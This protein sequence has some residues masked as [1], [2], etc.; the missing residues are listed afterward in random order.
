MEFWEQMLEEYVLHPEPM[1]WYELP[2]TKL[3]MLIHE[4]FD[5]VQTL[6]DKGYVEWAGVV[7]KQWKDTL[8]RITPEGRSYW[9]ANVKGR[10]HRPSSAGPVPRWTSAQ[11]AVAQ[12]PV[13]V[14]DLARVPFT[15]DKKKEQQ[16]SMN[17]VSD[18]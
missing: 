1:A 8:Y 2:A 9:E 18:L 3:R 10:R 12:S 11:L 13:S 15:W 6:A 16:E 5:A 4:Q 14:W 17:E 7:C